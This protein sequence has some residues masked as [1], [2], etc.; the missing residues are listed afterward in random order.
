MNQDIM[1]LGLIILGIIVV[2]MVVTNYFQTEGYENAQSNELEG[3]YSDNAVESSEGPAESVEPKIVEN[4]QIDDVSKSSA[5]QLMQNNTNVLPNPQMSNNYAPQPDVQQIFEQNQ[6]ANASCF[7]KDQL[8]AKDLLPKEDGYNTWQQANPQGQGHLSDKNFLE[9]GH[10]FGINT[11]GQSLKNANL[12]LRSDPV[13]PQVNV[14]PWQQSTYE[15]DTNR[16]A[17]EIGGDY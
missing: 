11:V 17:L 6:T 1:R 14:G 16:R 2:Y 12:G 7:P 9:S 13:I 15:Q 3:F 8:N 5:Q 10:H 4:T